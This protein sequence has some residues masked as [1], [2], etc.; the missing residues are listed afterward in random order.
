MQNS[1]VS[2]TSR[3]IFTRCED[4]IKENKKMYKNLEAG[5]PCTLKKCVFAPSAY[6]ESV[7][8]CTAG[9]FVINQNGQRKILMFHLDPNELENLKLDNIQKELIQK[10]GDNAV[11]RALLMG[12]KD[13][14]TS[15][16]Y[17][18]SPLFFN[19]L[20][21]F[22]Q[23]LNIPYSKLQGLSERDCANLSYDGKSDTWKVSTKFTSYLRKDVFE[24]KAKKAFEKVLI[25]KGD[26]FIIEQ[27]PTGAK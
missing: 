13:I 19:F 9:G 2:F 10:I 11:E 17:E 14:K 27:N 16:G 1:K 15:K 6:T 5:Y 12:S 4:H 3:I 8:T 7:R 24:Q 26:E 22:V 23:K 18:N 20:E 25:D 21:N